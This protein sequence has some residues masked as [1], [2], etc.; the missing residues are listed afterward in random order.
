MIGG[1]VVLAIIAVLL[2]ALGTRFLQTK[3][4]SSPIPRPDGGYLSGGETDVE[5]AEK[6]SGLLRWLTTVD[7]KDIGILYLVFGTVA[8][9]WGGTEAMMIRTELLTPT[10]DV[11]TAAT[12]NGLFTTHGI[13]ML[14]FFVTP[15]FFGIAN[16]F[17]PLLLDA[18]DMAFPRI[19]AIAF[20]M[21]PPSLLLSRAG[22]PADAL[23]K[24]LSTVGV[25]IPF[26]EALHPPETGWTL[27][28]PLSIQSG[29]PQVDLLLL[30]LHLSGIATT[31]GA[32]NFI[33]TVVSERGDDIGWPDIDIFSWTMLSTSG[34]V[35]FAFPLLGS[36]V[37]M[38]LLDRN[39]GTTFYLVEGGGPI[40]WQH[41]FWFFGH[42]EVYI[43]FLPATGLVSTI[44]PK[45]SSRK[46]FGFKFI[47][48]STLAIGVLSFGVWAHH[49]FSTGIDPRV[50]ASFMFVSLAIAVPSAVKV[51]NWISTMYD[52]RIRLTAPMI[53]AVGSIGTFILGGVTGVFLAAIPIDLVVHD[54]YFVVGHFHFIVMGIIPMMMFAASYYWY[55]IITGRMYD[56]LLA[57]LQA[58]LTIIGVPITFGS[59]LIMGALGL[60]RRYA[61]YPEQFA[62]LQQVASVGAF[63]IGIGVLLWLWNMVQSY[64]VGPRVRD[65]DVWKLKR[66]D[67]FTREWQWFEQKLADRYGTDGGEPDD[68]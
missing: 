20:W 44:L 63:I 18:D 38:M 53:F 62:M 14:F 50:R 64:R 16:Y 11:W 39:F 67:A 45:F 33:I 68:D 43:I 26:L 42:P 22:L 66:D 3:G 4:W 34:I 23:G 52:G 65:A 6:Q 31:L 24:L 35:L 12:Y 9:L 19:N 21:L 60:P 57:R 46:L 29:N 10:A 40:L 17:L 61:N 15:V 25:K 49:M 8:A 32:I 58:V 27:Y 2:V 30:G 36:A 1:G 48:Y 54:T 28:A 55:P 56:T 41:L 7:H 51:F 37:I 5:H 13:T 59:M 47:V